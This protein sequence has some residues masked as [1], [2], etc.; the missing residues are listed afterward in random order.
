[1][2]L[3]ILACRHVYSGKNQR[4]DDYEIYE[5]DA[6]NAQG[7]QIKQ[8]LR[9]FS[10]L[11]IGQDVEVTVTKFESER[12]GKSYTLN[13]KGRQQGAGNQRQINDMWTELERQGK[14]IA[15][16]ANRVSGLEAGQ[17]LASIGTSEP[18]PQGNGEAL[19]QRFGQEAPW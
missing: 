6:A 7:E 18:R 17:T 2:T 13:R 4:G 15:N 10:A 3:K 9:S 5:V 16:L 19:D 1:M 11:P 12:H 14:L 8:K